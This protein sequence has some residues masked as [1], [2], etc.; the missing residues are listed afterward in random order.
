MGGVISYFITK[1]NRD[2]K[3]LK[4]QKNYMSNQII[5][6]WNLEKLYSEDIANSSSKSAKTVLQEYRDKVE[7][8]NLIRP[9]MT[10][11]EARKILNQTL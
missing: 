1:S 11:K 4:S 9:L 8:M 3:R 2:Y 6:Y 7:A 5:S 10:E